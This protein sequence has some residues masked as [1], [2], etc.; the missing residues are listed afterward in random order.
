M[1]LLDLL[2]RTLEGVCIDGVSRLFS[3]QEFS[4]ELKNDAFILNPGIDMGGGVHAIE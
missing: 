4:G 3:P 2:T 1:Y